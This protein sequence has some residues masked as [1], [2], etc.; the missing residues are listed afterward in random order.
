MLPTSF[1]PLSHPPIFSTGSK[2]G[3]LHLFRPLCSRNMTT[4]DSSSTRPP[5][6]LPH[7]S[8]TPNC[9]CCLHGVYEWDC[10][11]GSLWVSA[12][13]PRGG[14][15]G[16]CG[17]RGRVGSCNQKRRNSFPGCSLYLVL[18]C[19][20]QCHQQHSAL[21]PPTHLDLSAAGSLLSPTGLCIMGECVYIYECESLC[22][23]VVL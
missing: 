3:H 1:P 21:P 9:F 4:A 2:M 12:G 8:L 6:L 10:V 18:Y 22:V 20:P 7:S 11:V 14:Y 13:P 5:L 17:A 16:L 19:V 15:L 23:I